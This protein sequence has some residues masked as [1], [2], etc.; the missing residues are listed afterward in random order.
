MVDDDSVDVGT[1]NNRHGLLLL[2]GII[3]WLEPREEHIAVF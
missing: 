1:S 2:P 3:V